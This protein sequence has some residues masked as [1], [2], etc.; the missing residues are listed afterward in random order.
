[1]L[2]AWKAIDIEE[3]SIR[4]LSLS[5]TVSRGTSGMV[6]SKFTDE[7]DSPGLLKREKGE[8]TEDEGSAVETSDK[9]D[10]GGFLSG[11]RDSMGGAAQRAWP[12]SERN[13]QKRKEREVE[14]VISSI[15]AL[16]GLA[17]GKSKVKAKGS[18]SLYCRCLVL[19]GVVH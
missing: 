12:W 8:T 18:F 10:G 4:D 15:A 1:V 7:E 17:P 2:P 11:V 3:L 16:Q 14:A 5:D 19:F 13:K 9:G 6:S